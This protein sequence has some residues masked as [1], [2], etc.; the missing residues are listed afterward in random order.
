MTIFRS[1]LLLALF[2]VTGW[3]GTAFGE[4]IVAFTGDTAGADLSFA[5]L[6]SS[7]TAGVY[8]VPY[9]DFNQ[10][11]A[12][13]VQSGLPA[14][15]G[16]VYATNPSISVGSYAALVRTTVSPDQLRVGWLRDGGQTN[17]SFRY[18]FMAMKEDWETLTSGARFGPTS[19]L[20]ISTVRTNQTGIGSINF[21]VK[22]GG[23]YYMSSS[24]LTQTLGTLAITDP[25]AASWGE[26]S[27]ASPNFGD[28]NP[29]SVVG[30]A[31]NFNDVEAVGFFVQGTA[32]WGGTL[33]GY[34]ELNN[35]TVNANAVPE[36][37]GLLF[38]V[39]GL[40]GLIGLRACRAKSRGFAGVVRG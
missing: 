32:V 18:L 14:L 40:I 13:D 39:V 16:G 37:S 7:W 3:H 10:V 27:A 29:T 34:I 22:N 8:A 20:S 15:R 9:S 2:T 5:N 30:T 1:C 28:V 4:A 25:N 31:Q 21:V 23:R 33:P 24:F 26:F 12:G 6:S 35:W 36:P 17:T 19:S 38:P 11:F